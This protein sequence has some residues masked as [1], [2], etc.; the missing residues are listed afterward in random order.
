M[1]W[2]WKTANLR[3]RWHK[4]LFDEKSVEQKLHA[5]Y[6]GIPK[7]FMV[8]AMV[9]ADSEMMPWT[10]FNPRQNKLLFLK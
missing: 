6:Y 8:Q 1:Q 5:Y 3:F 4:I 10:T 9:G 2:C 7:S